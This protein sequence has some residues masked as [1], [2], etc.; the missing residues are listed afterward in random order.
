MSLTDSLYLLMFGSGLLG[1]FGHC[2]G[3]CGPLVATYSLRLNR[4]SIAPHLLYNLGRITTY[5]LLGGL[6]GLTGSFTG[7]VKSIERFQNLTLALVGAA[8]IVMAFAI[9]G[10]IPFLKSR[11]QG[12]YKKEP[13]TGRREDTENERIDEENR[14]F[15]ASPFPR[16]PD[17][18]LHLI[19]RITRF[20]AET[21]GAGSFF[22][23]GLLLGFIP[24]GLLYTAL[25]AAAGAGVQAKNQIEGFFH[26]TLLLLL[27]GL[28]TAPAMFLL[29]RIVSLKSEWLRNRFY[30]GS[31]I[32]MIVMGV[33]FIYRAFR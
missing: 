26:G 3:M 14:R 5:S 10:W 1:G 17:Y 30:K 23:M 21:K 32:M 18:L 24:C 19:N 25:I 27:F 2:I 15:P 28:G 11:G 20:V 12:A 16:F 7:F 29:G 31:A 13:V 22:P 33:I 9:A 6:I 8:M 4:R